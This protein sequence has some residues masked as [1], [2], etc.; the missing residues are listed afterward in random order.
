MKL[1]APRSAQY[2][3]LA[4]FVA[5]SNNWVTDSVDLV[6]KTLGSTVALSTDPTQAGLTGPVANTV[7][8][9]CL[10]LPAGA[11][12][13][14][15]ELIVDTAYAGPTAATLSFGTAAATTS[16]L[17]SVSL[18]STGRTALTLTG[19]VTEGSLSD[20]ANLRMTLNYT[21]ANATAGK[22][23]LRV[24]YSVDGRAMEVQTT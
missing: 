2:P 12:I 6:S 8:F 23:R 4:Q 9:D 19:L 5:T 16:L 21:V 15:G 17:S 24:L 3:L 10:P 13:I 1:L 11:I 7:V 20:G 18:L 14:G 22:F